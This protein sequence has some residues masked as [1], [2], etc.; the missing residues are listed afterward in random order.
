L[1]EVTYC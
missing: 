1:E